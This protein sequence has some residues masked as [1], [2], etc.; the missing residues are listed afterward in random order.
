DLFAGSIQSLI[1]DGCEVMQL[2]LS[3]H[4]RVKFMLSDNFSLR[5]I[6]YQEE[7][8]AQANEME[9]ESK[10]QQYDADFLIMTDVLS[11]L[12]NDL[13]SLFKKPDSKPSQVS[14]IETIAE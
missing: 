3:W 14:E 7:V 12:I 6:Q 10:Q 5:T 4:D 8:I 13:I 2:A 9:P 1:N 11:A